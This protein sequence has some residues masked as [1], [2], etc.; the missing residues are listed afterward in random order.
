MG[1][2][3]DM[4]SPETEIIQKLMTI[5]AEERTG[6]EA[7]RLMAQLFWEVTHSPKDEK[8][9]LADLCVVSGMAIVCLYEIARE[10]DDLQCIKT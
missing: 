5:S 8:E 9:K 6:P 3:I 2:E 4:N 10:K 7:L 1:K